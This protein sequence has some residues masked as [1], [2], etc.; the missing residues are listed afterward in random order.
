MLYSEPAAGG[1]CMY[2]PSQVIVQ[3][4]FRRHRA[5]A[6][7]IASA[8]ISFGALTMGPLLRLGIDHYGMKG[9]LLTAGTMSLQCMVPAMLFFPHP[10]TRSKKRK[11]C[12]LKGVKL[13]YDE[14]CQD[15]YVVAVHQTNTEMVTH[16]CESQTQVNNLDTTSPTRLHSTEMTTCLDDTKRCQDNTAVRSW[17]RRTLA[18]ISRAINHTLDTSLLKQCGFLV[19]AA[20]ALPTST[21]IATYNSYSIQRAI[22]LG[23]DPVTASVIFTALGSASLLGRLLTGFVANQA[24]VNRTAQYGCAAGLVGVSVMLSVFSSSSPAYHIVMGFFCGFFVGVYTQ[25]VL[26]LLLFCCLSLFGSGLLIC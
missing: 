23:V 8:G 20:S 18:T 25:R 6:G 5:L 22:V 17:C 7:S 10:R 14:S 1:G 9:G 4:Y 12:D 26:L 21:G 16:F 3:H 2:I 11:S 24:C 15:G 19:F 13:T